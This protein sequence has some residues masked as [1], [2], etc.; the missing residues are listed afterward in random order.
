MKWWLKWSR[1]SLGFPRAHDLTPLLETVMSPEDGAFTGVWIFHFLGQSLSPQWNSVMLK[2]WRSVSHFV[3][4][5]SSR[6]SFVADVHRKQH[7]NSFWRSS[8][9]TAQWIRN[10]LLQK[11]QGILFLFANFHPLAPVW[12]IR[13]KW[14]DPHPGGTLGDEKS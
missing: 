8:S 10:T 3:D 5:K 12:Q 13:N 1:R 14:P 6:K 7:F 9:K 2:K 11:T 4:R